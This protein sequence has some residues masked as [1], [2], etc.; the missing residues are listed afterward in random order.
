MSLAVKYAESDHKNIEADQSVIFEQQPLD[1]QRDRS[2]MF[3]S[4]KRLGEDNRRLYAEL[5][6]LQMKYKIVIKES[7]M[8]RAAFTENT[9]STM[10]AF[11]LKEREFEL[12]NANLNKELNATKKDLDLLSKKYE[13]LE[14]TLHDEHIISKQK[15]NEI[16]YLKDIIDKIK[17]EVE[18]LK[19]Q[20]EKSEAE[21]DKYVCRINELIKD[22]KELLNKYK[23]VESEFYLIRKEYKGIVEAY[24]NLQ[25]KNKILT[26]EVKTLKESNSYLK[27]FAKRNENAEIQIN[28]TKRDEHI[29]QELKLK[30]RISQLEEEVNSLGEASSLKLT[31]RVNELEASLKAEVGA[32]TVL[33]QEVKEVTKK[34]DGLYKT[35]NATLKEFE[36]YKVS[37]SEYKRIKKDRE[38]LLQIVASTQDVSIKYKKLVDKHEESENQLDVYLKKVEILE[39]Q[40]KKQIMKNEEQ[41][42]TITRLNERILVL[43]EEYD[44]SKDFMRETIKN[45]NDNVDLIK[46]Q[47]E[48]I[49]ELKAEMK[50]QKNLYEARIKN[51]Y[52]EMEKE[53]AITKSA[54]EDLIEMNKQQ[55]VAFFQSIN[56][57]EAIMVKVMKKKKT[58]SSNRISLSNPRH[59]NLKSL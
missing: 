11:S 56:E 23:H 19:V 8:L 13:E 57:M 41:E 34:Y 27:K 15:S 45:R 55:E 51:F 20:K 52:K 47:E 46:R 54:C 49:N 59:Q 39:E 58:N 6:S 40:V 32:K 28:N 3:E 31:G 18:N 21:I 9:N 53:R 16:I 37:T 7:E 14:V 29:C 43:K 35:Y 44:R 17:Q 4:M 1:M 25:E 26:E 38:A 12:E 5:E 50:E 30:Q 2:L 42:K 33:E 10:E 48:T 36:Q 22:N 24:K